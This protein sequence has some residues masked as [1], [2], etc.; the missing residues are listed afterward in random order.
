MA[1]SCEAAQHLTHCLE[2]V[3]QSQGRKNR[4]LWD[5]V[6]QHGLG[7]I[8]PNSVSG[9]FLQLSQK[10]IVLEGGWQSAYG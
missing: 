2:E 6:V 5:S 1:S 4:S 9:A 3:Q 10:D 8:S 7:P